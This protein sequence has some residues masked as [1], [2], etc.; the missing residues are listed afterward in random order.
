MS[1]AHSTKGNE[2]SL[3]RNV[4]A[5]L[6]YLLATTIR[7]E[8]H[9]LQQAY[10]IRMPQWSRAQ[11]AQAPMGVLQSCYREVMCFVMEERAH[12]D[13]YVLGILYPLKEKVDLLSNECQDTPV[14]DTLCHDG[15]RP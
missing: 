4:A 14:L 7:P 8:T 3:H 10:F 12:Q 15:K 6:T 13:K 9:N 1:L 2:R 11:G 5:K